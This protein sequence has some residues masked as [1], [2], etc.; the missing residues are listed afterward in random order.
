MILGL[1]NGALFALKVLHG[2][3]NAT[4]VARFAREARMAAQVRHPNVVRIHDLGL[5][6]DGRMY[7]V[8]ELVEGTSLLRRPPKE[9]RRAVAAAIA[10]RQCMERL[11]GFL[12]WMSVWTGMDGLPPHYHDIAAILR[13]RPPRRRCSSCTMSR[14]AFTSRASR[15]SCRQTTWA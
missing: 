4:D 10:R 3:P 12:L 5:A 2:R 6:D 14:N 11:M 13:G 15:R 8:L 1:A 9:Q 7:V